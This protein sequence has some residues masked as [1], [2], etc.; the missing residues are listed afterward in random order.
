MPETPDLSVIAEHLAAV[1]DDD[2]ANIPEDIATNIDR[3]CADVHLL[4]AE[5]DRLRSAR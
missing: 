4:V 2:L 5:V 3:L 1:E